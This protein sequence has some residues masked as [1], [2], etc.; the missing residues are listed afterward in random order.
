[1]RDGDD[2]YAVA[3]RAID[4]VEREAVEAIALSVFLVPR[5]AI[6]MLDDLRVGVGDLDDESFREHFVDGRVSRSRLPLLSARGAMDLQL[7]ESSSPRHGALAR[8]RRR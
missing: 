8:A 3:Q 5:P 7:H 6:R 1:M 4:D 2:P